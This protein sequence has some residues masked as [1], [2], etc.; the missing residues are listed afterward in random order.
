MLRREHCQHSVFI[1]IVVRQFSGY[2]LCHKTEVDLSGFQPV[3]D[4]VIVSLVE[5]K[6]YAG[7][8]IPEGLHERRQKVAAHTGEGS[9]PDHL[10]AQPLHLFAFAG[11]RLLSRVNGCDIRCVC[12]AVLRPCDVMAATVNQ[13]GGKFFLHRFD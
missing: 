12:L 1:E 5:L 7:I 4:L 13:A 8:G 10:A 6:G 2:H 3:M 11:E 9:D